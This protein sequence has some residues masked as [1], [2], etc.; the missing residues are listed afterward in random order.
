ML[1]SIAAIRQPAKRRE[2]CRRWGGRSFIF[3]LWSLG[4]R[5]KRRFEFGL[6]GFLPS[7]RIKKAQFDVKT[8]ASSRVQP[9][10]IEAEFSDID[11]LSEVTRAWDLD[12]CQIERGRFSGSLFQVVWDDAQLGE[13]RFSRALEQTGI[14]PRGFRTFAIP[15]KQP[16]HLRWRGVDLTGDEIMIFPRGGELFSISNPDFHIFT[17][18]V[19]EEDLVA[20]GEWMGYPQIAEILES[21]VE[22]VR[23]ESRQ[24]KQ[25]IHRCR[26]AV[27][28]FK[29]R[30]T[31]PV[32][33]GSNGRSGTARLP[34]RGLPSV[35]TNRRRAK[36][37]TS[38]CRRRTRRAR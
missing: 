14:A 30:S 15:R 26:S 21:G 11:H 28:D 7:Y 12:F 33:P 20:S 19:R 1:D 4:Q 2:F 31:L 18:S 5:R 32:P 17:Y 23:S 8:V 16:L 38:V 25:L 27:V 13:A 24:L 22:V 35:N 3:F 34:A 37:P 10:S 29:T 9:F 6:L 36:R